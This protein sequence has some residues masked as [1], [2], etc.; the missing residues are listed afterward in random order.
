LHAV[1][2]SVIIIFVVPAKLHLFIFFASIKNFSNTCTTITP[3]LL[4]L[5]ITIIITS[6]IMQQAAAP[7]EGQSHDRQAQCLRR[8]DLHHG[9]SHPHGH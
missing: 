8:G 3:F 2:V 6:Y 4:S 7:K 9:E 1:V 5:I